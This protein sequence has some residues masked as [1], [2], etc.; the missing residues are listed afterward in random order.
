MA[1]TGFRDTRVLVLGCGNVLF[2]DDGF[3]PAAVAYLRD[4][5]AIPEDASLIDAGIGVRN[6]LFDVAIGDGGTRK[7]VIVD[8]VDAGREPG[9]I[10]SLDVAEIP[11]KKIDD[12]SM[13]QIPTSNLLREIQELRRV[14][15]RVICAQVA[16]IPE[17]VRPGLSETL[18][19]AVPL[20]CE[21]IL[22]EIRRA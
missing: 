11:A 17:S 21:K 9:E 3:G 13:H 15:V 10:F 12:F 20:A 16:S 8:A 22:E 18:A 4:H 19:R 5:F 7:I 1:E 2:G 14:E 6:I